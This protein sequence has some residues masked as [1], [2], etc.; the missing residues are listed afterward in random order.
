MVLSAGNCP[1]RKGTA[2]NTNANVVKIETR[3]FF[4]TGVP[5]SRNYS[6]SRFAMLV[7]K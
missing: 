7:H 4:L 1:S 6:H 5:L 2:V 3:V